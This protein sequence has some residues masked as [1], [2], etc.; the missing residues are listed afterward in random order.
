[1]YWEKELETLPVK[2]LRRLQVTR[3]NV[4]LEQAKRSPY[5]GELFGGNGAFPETIRDLEAVEKLP[6]TEK[7]H[8]RNNFPYGF[9]TLPPKEIIRLHSSS[10]TTG[11]PT[12]IFHNRHDI[13][14]WSNLMARSLFCAGVRDTDVFQNIVGYGLFTGGLGFQYGIEKLGALSIPAGAGNSIRQIKLMRDY[15]T[16][17]IHAIPSYMARLYDVFLEEKLDPRKDTRLRLLCIGA[18]PHTEEQR[19]RIQEM[20]GVKA[21]NSFGLSEMNGPG[22]AFEC[23]YQTGLHIWE[24]AFLVEIVHP[25]TLQP[26]PE[27]EYGELVMTTLDREANP[28]IRYR[29]RD[30]TRFIPGECPCGRT[31]RRIDRIT[32]RTDDMFILRGCN[33]FPMQVEGVLMKIPEV[34]DDYR[35][36]LE[37]INDQDALVIDVEIRREWFRGD[38]V[39]LD[40]LQKRLTH[41]IR[42][43]VLV[44][45]VIRLVEPGSLPKAEGKAVRVFD[46]RKR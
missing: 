29:T 18:E 41:L 10:G 25:D 13:E 4:T 37:T 17:A 46:K 32:G 16:T 14:S 44:T 8:L 12:V 27:G 2:G 40:K 22:V 20:F 19:Q 42:D 24:D 33:I 34:G 1:M 11:N 39:Y 23:E 38:M 7:Q 26:V 21:F 31:H 15:G 30:I 6:F 35:I 3:L 45:P 28:L 9:L 43:E 36:T 5:Y